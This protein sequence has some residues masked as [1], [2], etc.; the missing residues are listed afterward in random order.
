M[1][2]DAGSYHL[3][4]TWDQVISRSRAPSS[5]KESRRDKDVQHT[6]KRKVRSFYIIDRTNW[7]NLQQCTHY[8]HWLLIKRNI[9]RWTPMSVSVFCMPRWSS[10]VFSLFLAASCSL[11]TFVRITDNLPVVHDWLMQRLELQDI[12]FTCSMHNSIYDTTKK[13]GIALKEKHGLSITKFC[14]INL[15]GCLHC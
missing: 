1:N 14:T 13:T 11:N 15:K 10:R 5:C 9:K 6:S 2:R 3:S 8:C 12:L 4:H 7:I